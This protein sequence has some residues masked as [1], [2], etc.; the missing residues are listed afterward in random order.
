MAIA[1]NPKTRT[2]LIRRVTMMANGFTRLSVG[3][4]QGTG[5]GFGRKVAKGKAELSL[6]LCDFASK[7][8]RE[9]KALKNSG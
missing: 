2:R 8:Y 3:K 6:R 5:D 9:T 1:T 4:I 7:N